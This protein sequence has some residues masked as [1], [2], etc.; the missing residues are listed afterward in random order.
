MTMTVVMAHRVFFR[1]AGSRRPGEA[2]DSAASGGA[3]S[4]RTS[5]ASA[6]A[7]MTTPHAQSQQQPVQPI[8]LPA[9]RSSD[10]LANGCIGLACGHEPCPGPRHGTVEATQCRTASQHE[11]PAARLATARVGLAARLAATAAEAYRSAHTSLASASL[12]RAC[13][14]SLSERSCMISSDCACSMA[15]VC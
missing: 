1:R 5:L 11:P 15:R 12:R 3:R 14:S 8:L 2:L 10:P 4:P 6:L 9:T 7:P 13:S